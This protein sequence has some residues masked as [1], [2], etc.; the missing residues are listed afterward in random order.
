MQTAKFSKK[1]SHKPEIPS[2]NIRA[3]HAKDDFPTR[4]KKNLLVSPATLVFLTVK[5]PSV[6]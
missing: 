5:F 3:N 4:N 2:C 6:N 1:Y